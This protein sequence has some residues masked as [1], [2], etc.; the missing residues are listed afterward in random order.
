MNAISISWVATRTGLMILT[1]GAPAAL[2]RPL[3]YV[4]LGDE[5]Q[6]GGQGHQ[7]VQSAGG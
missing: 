4:P 3:I 2:A 5:T 6:I 7:L 1:L